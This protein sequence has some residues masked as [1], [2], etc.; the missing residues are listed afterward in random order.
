MTARPGNADIR[1][2]ARLDER[3]AEKIASLRQA[4]G[5]SLS[6]L[7]RQSVDRYY[8][9]VRTEADHRRDELDGLVGAAGGPC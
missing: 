8:Q 7:L 4:T 2:N 1:I 5:L 9:P 6:D 3:D